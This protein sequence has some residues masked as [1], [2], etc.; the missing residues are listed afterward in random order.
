MIT[1]SGLHFT[2]WG[3]GHVAVSIKLLHLR[4][5]LL[6]SQFKPI[7]VSFVA[8]SVLLSCM[9]FFQGH[10]RIFSLTGPQWFVNA[11]HL[12]GLSDQ[13]WLVNGVLS[14]SK[15]HPVTTSTKACPPKYSQKLLKPC[16]SR[17]LTSDMAFKQGQKS[18]WNGDKPHTVLKMGYSKC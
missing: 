16:W 8:I 13:L 2:Y 18:R 11:D 17:I 15:Q 14:T 4:F 5:S 3:A 6:Q 12:G 1:P 7:F 9:L 10:V